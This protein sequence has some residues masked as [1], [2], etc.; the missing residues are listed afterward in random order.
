MDDYPYDLGAH[1]LPVSTRSAVAQ[2]WFDRG[3]T[4]AYGFN[5]EEAVRCFRR[6]AEADPDCAMA[7]WGVAYAA[8]PNYNMP[9]DVFDEAGRAEALATAFA[10]LEAARACAPP[11]PWEAA[12][13]AAL[14]HRF[15]QAAPAQDTAAWDAAYAE[16]MRG[17]Q[18]AF[19]DHLDIRAL[20]VEALMQ[21]T[22]WAMWD[23]ATGQIAE[24]AA[25]ETC[26]HLCETA[27]DTD[28]R[29]WRHP[30][31][32]HLYV[33]L[34][35]MSPTP[36]A[37]LRAGDV[38]RT[39]VPDAG[40]LVHM[41]THI[42]VQVGAYHDVI[43]WNEA[44]VCADLKYYDR[45][46]AANLYTGYRQHNYHFVV[47]GAMFAGQLGPARRALQGL[48]DTTPEDFLRI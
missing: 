20:T 48:R 4:W 33:H 25:T 23:I 13:I 3:L 17:V 18:A 7:H 6:A 46:G 28:P 24:G 10:A 11:S 43:H 5:H 1:S 38:L 39:L 36:E 27:F 30:G 37:A 40:H 42:D 45:E 26:Q 2:R 44:A 35:E 47:Y 8:G 9:W 29:A 21:P 15:P 34:M 32:L 19:P 31:L 12:L 22:P 14:A 41:P 16:A